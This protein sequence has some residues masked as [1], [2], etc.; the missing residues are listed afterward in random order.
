MTQQT[1]QMF[2]ANQQMYLCYP[3]GYEE[4]TAAIIA[5]DDIDAGRKAMLNLGI[6]EAVNLLG[7]ELMLTNLSKIFNKQGYEIFIQTKGL[8]H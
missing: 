5:K 3:K 6:R 8:F 1:T 7:A 4:R 2:E